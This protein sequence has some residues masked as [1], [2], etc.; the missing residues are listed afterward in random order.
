[1]G[2]LSYSV[3]TLLGLTSAS[4]FADTSDIKEYDVENFRSLIKEKQLTFDVGKNWVTDYLSKGGDISQVTGLKRPSNWRRNARFVNLVNKTQLPAAFDWRENVPGGLQPIR[5]QGQCGSCWAFSVTAVLE[6]LVK[7]SNPLRNIDVAEQAV[8]A[9]SRAGSCSGGYFSAF[10]YLKNPG[11]PDESFDPYK[12][13]NTSCKTDAVPEA[14]VVSWAYITNNGSSPTTDQIKTAV[15][16]YGPVSVDVNASFSSYKEGIYN[17][18]NTS[19][20]NHMVNIEG[21]NDDG[22]Y[23]I[24][25]NSWGTTWGE[26][27]YMRIKYVNSSGYKCNGI[28]RVAAFAVYNHSK[29]ADRN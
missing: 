17:Y 25:R 23:W 7:I 16:Q 27:G 4:L 8:V 6:S 29:S 15:M 10:N 2:S 19:G 11:P 22:Q 3:I 14:N 21:W 5:N 28:G 26:A 9:C 12:A 24:M 20:T 18:C 13:V 1:M